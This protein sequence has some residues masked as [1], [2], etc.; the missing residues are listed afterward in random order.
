MGVF[1]K[2]ERETIKRCLDPNLPVVEVGGCIGVVACT[3]NR[4][5]QEPSKHVVVEA[6]PD[7]VPVLEANRQLN[8]CEFV[9]LQ[10]DELGRLQEEFR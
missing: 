5:L 4:L 1:E 6:N 9:V 8:Q 2:H 3:T 7:L 10:R